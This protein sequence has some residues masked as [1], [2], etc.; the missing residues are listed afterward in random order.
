M[1]AAIGEHVH[2]AAAADRR[3][4][5]LAQHRAHQGAL[6]QIGFRHQPVP[7]WLDQVRH[8]LSVIGAASEAE[9][10]VPPRNPPADTAASP[11]SRSALLT[12]GLA[13]ASEVA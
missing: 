1:T 11:A 6:A 4:R 2:L 9:R 10:Q 5:N 7:A 12:A 8:R 13:V 3:D